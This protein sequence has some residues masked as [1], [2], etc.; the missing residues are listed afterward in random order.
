MPRVSQNF[1]PCER[2]QQYLMPVSLRDWL[3]EDHLA[4]FVLD[5]VSQMDLTAFYGAYRQDG[6]GRAAYEPGMLV[7]LLLYAYCEGVNSARKLIHPIAPK[8]IHL[9]VVDS[10]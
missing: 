8:V 9:G 7:A 6:W 2:D 10:L 3:P 4:W 5:A 1:L